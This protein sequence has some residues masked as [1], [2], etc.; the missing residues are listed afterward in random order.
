MRALSTVSVAGSTFSGCVAVGSGGAILGGTASGR[1]VSTVSSGRIDA[2]NSSPTAPAL[3]V[4][5]SSF[6]NCTAAA[7]RRASFRCRCPPGLGLAVLSLPLC[8]HPSQVGG[9]LAGQNIGIVSTSF[10]SCRAKA[11]DMDEAHLTHI[12]CCAK[13]DNLCLFSLVTQLPPERQEAQ[14]CGIRHVLPLLMH[15]LPRPV[16]RS[17]L[18]RAAPAE[19]SP[20]T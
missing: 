1:A 13:S 14:L 16:G 18:L 4:T 20:W 10:S 6:V 11:R 3:V 2:G 17:G 12:V 19:L 15:S 8:L 7:V 9:A 5:A